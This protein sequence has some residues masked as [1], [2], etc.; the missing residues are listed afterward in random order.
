MFKG[1]VTILA[2]L[3]ENLYETS[4]EAEWNSREEFLVCHIVVA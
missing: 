1:K 3:E 4:F 2:I